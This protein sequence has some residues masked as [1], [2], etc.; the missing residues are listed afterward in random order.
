MGWDADSPQSEGEVGICGVAVSSIK[1]MDILFDKIPLDKVS[2]SM[3]INSPAAMIFA[4][5]LAV[6]RERNID[7]K[8]STGHTSRMIFSKN[9]LLKKNIFIHQNLQC[10][11]SLI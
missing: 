3:T 8:E 1:D 9:T 11:S 5:Y 7:F 10:E 4:M 6:A 2:T